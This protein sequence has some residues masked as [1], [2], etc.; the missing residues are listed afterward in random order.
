MFG[1]KG[2]LPV[3]AIFESGT[4]EQD[5]K[6][7]EEYINNLK[8]RLEFARTAVDKHANKAR[9]KQKQENQEEQDEQKQD[10][11]EK[12]QKQK[13]NQEQEHEHE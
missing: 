4:E 11:Q 9:E 5:H 2:K 3:D 13:Q 7:T 12:R 1:R 8:R 6:S 10:E